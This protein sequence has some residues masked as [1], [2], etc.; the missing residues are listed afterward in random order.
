AAMPDGTGLTAFAE[1]YPERFFDVAIAEQHAITFAAGMATQ[2]LKPVVAVYSTFMQRAFDQIIEDVAM[3]NLPVVLVLDRAGLVGEDGETHHGVYDLSYLRLIPNMTLLVAAEP[4]DITPM[5]RYALR[6]HTPVALRFPKGSFPTENSEQRTL[7]PD[8]I[9]LPQVILPAK[10][11]LVLACG[12]VTFAAKS[13]LLRLNLGK[14][15][16]IGLINLRRI[17]PLPTEQLL[18]L[19]SAA[20]EIAIVEENTTIGGFGSAIMEFCQ[21][22][23]IYPKFKLIGIPDRFIQQGTASQLNQSLQL[24]T[25]SLMQRFKEFFQI[26][27]E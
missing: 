21:E 12:P 7:R 2:G 5:L 23:Q 4:T 8:E 1:R 15:P 24:D 11:K 19:L 26:E 22:N 20:E 3:Q 25:I 13:A 18:F 27:Q 16:A 9:P 14:D 10:K 17:K 6:L